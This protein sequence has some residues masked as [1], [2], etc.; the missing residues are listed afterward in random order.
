MTSVQTSQAPARLPAAEALR[1][2]ARD[3]LQAI[4]SRVEL[5]EPGAHGVHASTPI[6]GDVLFTVAETTPEQADAVIAEAAQ[7]FTT[8]RTTPAPVRGALVA[9]LGELLKEHKDDLASLVTIEAG[10]ITSEALGEVQE[11]IDICEFAVGLSRQLYGKTIASERPGHRLMETWHPLGVVGVIT[12]FNF[13][14]AVWAWNAAIALVCGDTLVW[15]PSELT[16][17][18]ALACQALAERAADDVGAPRAVSRLVH[19]RA[20]G[21]RTPGRR[22]AGGAGERDG[23]GADGSAGRVRGWRSGS[24]RCCS[25]WAATTP[26]SSRRRPISNSPCAASCSPR[27]APRASA[28]RRCDG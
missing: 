24:A 22:P 4:G 1:A 26:R 14:V 28:A 9:R 6:T 21:R 7:A 5:G 8:W 3:A 10:K 11:M 16:P 13:P 17:L 12:A 19:G 23:F 20:A 15:K 2:K 18:T 27:R 25:N